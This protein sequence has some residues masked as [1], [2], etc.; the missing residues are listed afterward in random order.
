MRLRW[1]RRGEFGVGRRGII[2]S[3]GDGHI[4]ESRL[5]GSINKRMQRIGEI[6][7]GR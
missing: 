3:V 1:P 4:G 6:N 5:V 2:F 7:R